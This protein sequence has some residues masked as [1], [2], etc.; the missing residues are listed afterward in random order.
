MA[1]VLKLD[2]QTREGRGSQKAKH[3]RRT[4]L[5]PAVVYGHK[6]ATV[7]I[8]LPGDALFKAI[9]D[10]D[11]IVVHVTAKTLEPEAAAEAV[12]VAAE[13]A[14]PEVIGRKVAAEEE[15]AEK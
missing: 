15:E 10:P 7:S 12:P 1:E 9:D 11:V 3:L 4:G 6:E 13:S 2:T 14:E 5:V 8:A